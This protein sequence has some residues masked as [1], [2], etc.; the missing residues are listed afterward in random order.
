VPHGGIVLEVCIDST[1][2]ATFHGYHLFGTDEMM[3]NAEAILSNTK[4]YPDRNFYKQIKLTA[5]EKG[6]E[7]RSMLGLKLFPMEQECW[8]RLQKMSEDLAKWGQ[9]TCMSF[10]KESGEIIFP[11]ELILRCRLSPS[12]LSPPRTAAAA[13]HETA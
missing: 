13:E 1:D 2:Y 12:P 4:G 5:S 10:L 8:D 11:K 3:R 7:V 6:H 9:Y